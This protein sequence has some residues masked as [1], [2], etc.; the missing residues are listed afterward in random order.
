MLATRCGTTIPRQLSTLTG[1]FTKT[2]HRSWLN[3]KYADFP[4]RLSKLRHVLGVE[5]RVFGFVNME[6]CREVQMAFSRNAQSW[7]LANG[8]S[9]ELRSREIA[10]GIDY[11]IS[12][13]L[14]KDTHWDVDAYRANQSGCLG[15][16]KLGDGGHFPRL[17]AP[18]T[19]L[20]G[21]NEPVGKD[22]EAGQGQCS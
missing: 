14:R 8:P 4:S 5:C 3:E 1:K 7:K 9:D 11:V 18:P 13:V 10:D 6:V 16:R 20:P 22:G 19:L 17:A 21:A 2:R 15:D 12:Y